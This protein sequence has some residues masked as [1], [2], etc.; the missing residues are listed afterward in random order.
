MMIYQ[1]R[2]LDSYRRIEFQ[3]YLMSIKRELADKCREQGFARN[4]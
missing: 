3:T 1:I 2:G 4:I